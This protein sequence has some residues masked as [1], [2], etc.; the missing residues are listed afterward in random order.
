MNDKTIKI[1][2][3]KY[4]E[5]QSEAVKQKYCRFYKDVIPAFEM[6]LQAYQENKVENPI[7]PVEWLKTSLEELKKAH[8]SLKKFS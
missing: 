7:W 1:T 6:L 3:E 2:D 4:W 8:E 5:N